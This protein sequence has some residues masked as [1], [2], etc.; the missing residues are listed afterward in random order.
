M[1]DLKNKSEPE[2][3]P[4]LDDIRIGL[5]SHEWAKT[6]KIKSFYFKQIDSTNLRAKNE[7]FTDDTLNEQMTLYFADSQTEGRGRGTNKWNSTRDGAQLLSTW[8]FMLQDHVLPTLSPL[9]G[10]ALFKACTATW[11]FLNWNLKAPNDLYLNDRKVAGLLIETVSQASDIRLLIGLGLNVIASPEDVPTSTSL[12]A[13]LSKQTPLLAQDWISFLER[14][15]FEVSI[16][17][18]MAAEPLDSTV[19]ASLK[20]ALNQS[21][22]L[23]EKFISIDGQGNL[24]T[25]NKKTNWSEL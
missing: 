21:P 3:D 16:A 6:Q 20:F 22:I 2:L 10:L 23:K 17:I 12:V 18:Q 5:V 1:S 9:V 13:E 25:A 14:F 15:L 4:T 8:S 7:A 24:Y 11:P 19:C